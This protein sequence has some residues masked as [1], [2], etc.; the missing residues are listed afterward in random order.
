MLRQFR[1]HLVEAEKSEATRE[2]YMWDVTA[3]AEYVAA[4]AVFPFAMKVL[5]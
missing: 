3:F 1:Q 2:K 5:Q 4:A